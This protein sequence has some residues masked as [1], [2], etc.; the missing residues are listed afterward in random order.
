MRNEQE[1]AEWLVSQCPQCEDG[2]LGPVCDD[3][4]AE[5]QDEVRQIL[6]AA[7]IAE[8]EARAAFDRRSD[9]ASRGRLLDAL[10][11]AQDR[12]DSAA[13]AFV[14]SLPRLHRVGVAWSA[15][16]RRW[17]GTCVE[18]DCD[19]TELGAD[20]ASPGEV[21]VAATQHHAVDLT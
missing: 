13:R 4:S 21:L 14:L 11:N 5:T 10:G 3:H 20:G 18:P 12:T 16:E 8:A 19:F 15:A 6:T 9:T 7:L 2:G 17:F 1:R